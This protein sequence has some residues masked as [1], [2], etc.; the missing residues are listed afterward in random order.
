MALTAAGN[1]EFSGAIATT[2]M[3]ADSKV[4]YYLSATSNNGKTITKP[5]TAAQGGYY[6][7]YAGKDPAGI[8]DASDEHFGQFFPNPA[9]GQAN[10]DITLNANDRYE[11][12]FVDMMGRIAH[13]STLQAEGAIRY[14][15]DT[16][17]LQSGSY[18]VIFQSKS[19]RVVRRLVVK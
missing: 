16:D 13:R 7:F 9:E 15:V 17:K 2:G 8:E 1:N 3:A 10:I 14:S 6:T 5:M 4:E 11:V 19:E 12:L 18:L